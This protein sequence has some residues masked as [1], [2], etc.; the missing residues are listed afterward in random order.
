MR[1][2]GRA[3]LSRGGRTMGLGVLLF[4]IASLVGCGTAVESATKRDLAAAARVVRPPEVAPANEAPALYVPEQG[5]RLADYVVYALRHNPEVKASFERWRAA[6]L[7]I[8]AARRLPEPRINYGYFVR[9]VETRVG[10]QRHRLGLSQTFPWPTRLSAGADAASEAARAAQKRFDAG[11]L[12]VRQQVADAYWRLWLIQEDHRLKSEHDL[13]LETLAGTVRGRVSTGAAS[14]ADLNQVELDIARHHDHHGEHREAERAASAELLRAIGSPES[15]NAL[16][17]TDSPPEGLPEE[18]QSMLRAAARDHPRIE[19]LARRASASESRARAETAKRF[20]S[21]LT[22]LEWIETGEAVTPDVPDSGQDAVIVS[23]GLSIPL[24]GRSYREEAEAERADGAAYRADEEAAALHADAAV[25][26]ALAAVR[27]AHR[28]TLLYRNTL[29]PQA[30]TTLRSVLGSYR[31]GRSTVASA[32]LAQRELLELQLELAKSRAEHARA[33]AV[34]ERV[35]G[36]P[37][38]IAQTGA[39]R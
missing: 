4:G 18:D 1:N 21:F 6:T 31:T 13:V 28:R 32:L 35:V 9:S 19:E 24:W 2:Q 5:G 12:A 7:R 11:L 23:A 26:A 34:L 30:E 38:G 20:P 15:R 27:D 10:P 16:S 37:V 39:E 22:G 33:W 14:L 29:I 17:T 25:A 8:S 3:D 36:R